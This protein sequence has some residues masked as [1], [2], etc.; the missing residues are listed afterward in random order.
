[1]IQ[2]LKLV[3]FPIAAVAMLCAH[4]PIA[5]AAPAPAIDS[6]EARFLGQPSTQPS[7]LRAVPSIIASFPGTE[8]IVAGQQFAPG[9]RVEIVIPTGFFGEQALLDTVVTAA[10][11][12][13][14]RSSRDCA[15]TPGT[16]ELTHDFGAELARGQLSCGETLDVAATDLAPLVSGN[17]ATAI[18]VQ[19][20]VCD[21][22]EFPT[23][24]STSSSAAGSVDSSSSGTSASTPL[25]GR[26]RA[27]LE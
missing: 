17:V 10:P 23:T 14:C 26:P 8:L 6:P 12:V 11:Q 5:S 21:R 25:T 1:M 16:F 22:T 24:S 3:V 20:T 18:N 2:Q 27:N 7:D 4:S 15:N 13:A 9:D 19:I